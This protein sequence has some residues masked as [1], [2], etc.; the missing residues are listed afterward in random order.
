MIYR[1]IL[2]YNSL[3]LTYNIFQEIIY[4]SQIL[5]N[6]L[7]IKNFYKNLELINIFDIY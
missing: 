6:F 2:Y 7:V 1:I 4:F 5:Y 3:H